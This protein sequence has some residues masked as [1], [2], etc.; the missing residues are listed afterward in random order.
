M[1]G[2]VIA[3]EMKD[4]LAFVFYVRGFDRRRC[5]DIRLVFEA[6]TWR[7]DTVVSTYTQR[8]RHIRWFQRSAIGAMVLV[9]GFLG[10]IL[11]GSQPAVSPGATNSYA[12]VQGSKPARQSMKTSEQSSTSGT[13][14]QRETDSQAV[15]SAVTTSKNAVSKPRVEKLTFHLTEGMPLDKLS[16]FLKAHHL[17]QSVV[18]FDMLMHST[19]AD[20]DVKP[21]VYQFTTNM[22]QQQLIRT[23]K[24][25]PSKSTP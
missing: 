11:H 16:Q 5:I 6:Q 2:E 21:G 4:N 17:I 24:Q 20:R 18:S 1:R 13:K 3:V 8:L 23:L 14:A 22:T 12:S 15:T 9:A 19:K 7:I 25:G 10:Y